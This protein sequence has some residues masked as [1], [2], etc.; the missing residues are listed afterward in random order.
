MLL[1]RAELYD[2][3]SICLLKI[4]HG[5]DEVE[6]EAEA[7]A[8][9]LNMDPVDLCVLKL[10]M[11][12]TAIF[13]NEDNVRE[14]SSVPDMNDAQW[15]DLGRRLL[16]THRLNATRSELKKRISENAQERVDPKLNYVKGAWRV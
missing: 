14:L 13:V 1:T 12:N 11:V 16:K 2:R 6:K 7:L 15:A 5:S 8:Q 4:A 3:L 9:E 10:A